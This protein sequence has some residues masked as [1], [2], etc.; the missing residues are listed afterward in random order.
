MYA[1]DDAT[2]TLCRILLRRAAWRLQYKIRTQQARECISLFDYQAYSGSFDMEIVSEL[3][4]KELLGGI[5]WEKCRYVIRR[6]IIEGMTEKEVAFE[7]QITQQAV[8]KWK[9][10]GLEILRQNL[11]HSA[12]W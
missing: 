9:R 2:I 11:K 12:N 10:K 5:P 7:L 4:V 3:Y 8:N 1:N 6:I